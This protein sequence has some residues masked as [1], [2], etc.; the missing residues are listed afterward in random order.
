MPGR[1]EAQRRAAGP[2]GAGGG[3][4]RGGG[5][6]EGELPEALDVAAREVEVEL[7]VPARPLR[8]PRGAQVGR[9]AGASVFLW[10]LATISVIFT[11][12]GAVAVTR[13]KSDLDI[14]QTSL[15][16]LQQHS[17]RHEHRSNSSYAAMHSMRHELEAAKSHAAALE[18]TIAELREEREHGMS[19]GHKQSEAGYKKMRGERDECRRET[20]KVLSTLGRRS[21]LLREVEAELQRCYTGACSEKGNPGHFD[22]PLEFD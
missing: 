18:A 11:L 2:G 16:H 8:H 21:R 5:W 6:Q 14:A 1:A 3:A 10:Y 9:G 22:I 19:D 13:Q 15:H 17:L 7:G 20:A 12:L 4:G